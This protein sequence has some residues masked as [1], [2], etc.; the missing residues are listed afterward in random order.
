MLD[1]KDAKYVSAFLALTYLAYALLP[2][3]VFESLGIPVSLSMQPEWLGRAVS[4]AYSLGFGTIAYGLQKRTPIFWRL[5]PILVIAYFLLGFIYLF[6]FWHERSLSLFPIWIGVF[7]FLIVAVFFYSR[8]R[9]MR[10]YFGLPK[11]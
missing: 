8:W 7:F 3:R 9:G 2:L 6:L 4:L 10:S 5:I 1:V 11:D